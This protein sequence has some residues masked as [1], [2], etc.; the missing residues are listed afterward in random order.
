MQLKRAVSESIAVIYLD[1]VVCGSIDVM[2]LDSC[3]LEYYCHIY[4]YLYMGALLSYS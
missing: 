4:R 1:R 3:I 2:Y